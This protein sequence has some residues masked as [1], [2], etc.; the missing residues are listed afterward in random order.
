M[1]IGDIILIVV[2]VVAAIAAGL[3]FLNKW[4]YGKINTQQEM[5]E[6]SKQVMS[7]F[8]I[9]KKKD[10]ITNVNMPKAVTEQVPKIYKFLKMYFVRAKAGPQIITFLCDKKIFE[11]MP[12]KK[13]IKVELAGIYIV[14]IIGMKSDAELKEIKKKKK[15][16]NKEKKKKEKKA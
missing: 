10:K 9:D 12:V 6:K 8:V 16:E 1:T 11:A 14:K 4:A 15:Q 5:I 2:L 3:Y 13:N 7:I